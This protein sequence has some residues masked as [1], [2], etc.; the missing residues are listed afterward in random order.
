MKSEILVWVQ[1]LSILALGITSLHHEYPVWVM[2][3]GVAGILIGMWALFA[4]RS[5]VLTV[6]PEVHSETQL[7]TSGPYKYIRHPMY[8]SLLLVG[9]SLLFIDP[10]WWRIGILLIFVIN[11]FI[12]IDYEESLLE[13]HFSMYEQYKKSTAAL[14]PFIY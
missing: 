4:M 14:F 9:L 6:Y 5:S 2:G 12:K 7:V 10:V 8:L 3:I 11:M 13:K 1:F